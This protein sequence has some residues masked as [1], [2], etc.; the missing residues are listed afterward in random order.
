MIWSHW[1]YLSLYMIVVVATMFKNLPLWSPRFCLCLPLSGPQVRIRSTPLSFFSLYY[2]NLIDKRSKINQKE[3]GIGPLYLTFTNVRRKKK[4]AK[5]F[6]RLPKSDASE[7]GSDISSGFITGGHDA[8]RGQ[9][10]FAALLGYK[11]LKGTT[12]TG[13]IYLC[14]GSLIN[15]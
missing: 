4:M 6:F 11:D 10:P 9:Y 15:R 1:L 2:W 7:C 5:F 14:G 8:K 12:S 3:A 13:V